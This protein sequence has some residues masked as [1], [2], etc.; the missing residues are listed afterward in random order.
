MGTI[1]VKIHDVTPPDV[2]IAF[3]ENDV[4]VNDLKATMTSKMIA[5]SGM[6]LSEEENSELFGRTSFIF[7]DEGNTYS[8]P[9][10]YDQMTDEQKE[11]EEKKILEQTKVDGRRDMEYPYKSVRVTLAG[12][13]FT[14][15]GNALSKTDGKKIVNTVEEDYEN[16][17]RKADVDFTKPVKRHEAEKD[18]TNLELAN[19]G[20]MDLTNNGKY[21]QGVG[22][23][24]RQ[25][26]SL[27]PVVMYC[28]N[29]NK[30]KTV[31]LIKSTDGQVEEQDDQGTTQETEQQQSSS[32]YYKIVRGDGSEVEPQSDG[33]YLFRV[34]N[35]PTET[36]TDQPK[37]YFETE[38]KD[39]A[40]N[41][42]HVRIPLY[43][44][45]NTATDETT[46]N[47]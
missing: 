23:Y 4:D 36:F 29:G 35:Y 5:S 25:N 31:G 42:T 39:K 13:I 16:L 27:L 37:Y 43:V 44:V 17:N 8:K 6:P 45:S 15:N 24:A 32:S 14:A 7:I 1:P 3:Q 18:L 22:V 47:R 11:A 34:A 12:N 9:E 30:R 40:Q 2:W 10:G 38:V 26:V 19:K 41:I 28:D 46:S 21:G 33:T 20:L